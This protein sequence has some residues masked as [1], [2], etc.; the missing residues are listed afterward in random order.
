M[1]YSLLFSQLASSHVHLPVSFLES[2]PKSS[3]DSKATANLIKATASQI[4]VAR[5]V[6]Y[7]VNALESAT[8]E[9]AVILKTAL[10]EALADNDRTQAASKLSE[11]VSLGQET[12]FSLLKSKLRSGEAITCFSNDP[13]T[14]LAHLSYHSANSP[15]PKSVSLFSR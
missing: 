14:M 2:I 8:A 4:S 10:M 13:D 9:D 5:S 15:L 12:S 3:L 6:D 11:S 7:A 1:D